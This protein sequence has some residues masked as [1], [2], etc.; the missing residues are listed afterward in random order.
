MTRVHATTSRPAPVEPTAP[1]GPTAPITRPT[2]PTAPTAS[3]AS[4]AHTGP[5]T[6][7][8]P[9]ADSAANADSEPTPPTGPIAPG[10][11]DSG[12]A[13]APRFTHAT[14]ATSFATVFREALRQRGLPLE[15]VRERLEARGIRISLATLSY[16]QRGRSQPE[17]VQSL[18]AVDELENILALPVGALRCLLGPHRPRGRAVNETQDLTA[19]QRIFGENSTV[20]QALG[21]AFAHFNEDVSSLVIRETVRLDEH[22]CIRNT[23]VHQVLRAT[24]AGASRVTVVHCIDDTA[25]E[26]IDVVVRCG[27]PGTIR[28]L[29]ELRSI[30]IEILFGRELAKNETVVVDYEISLGRSQLVSTHHERRTRVN[31]REYL[32]HVYFHPDALPVSCHRYYREHL[33]AEQRYSRRIAID[34]SHTAHMLPIRCPA[35]IHGMSWEWPDD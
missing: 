19:S 26:S 27:K 7:S 15:R 20:E 5:A 25:A 24:R 13:H 14:A 6:P 35:G 9:N 10:G 4:A 31:L 1:T 18:L 3:T 34:V 28:F 21:A 12:A 30:V 29:P 16:W 11:C 17:R 23:A 22:R 33:G 8:G 2:A 32:L